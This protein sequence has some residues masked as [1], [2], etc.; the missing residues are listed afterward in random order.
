MSYQ[1]KEIEKTLSLYLINFMSYQT[2]EIE[3]TLSLYLIL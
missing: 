3:K 1:T 2:K